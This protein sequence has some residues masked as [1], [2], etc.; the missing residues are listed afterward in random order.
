M[1]GHLRSNLIGYVALFVALGG[2]SYAA[3][4]ITTADLK[5]GVVTKKKL[6]RNAVVPGK[7]RKGAVTGPKVSDGAITGPK[8]SDGAIDGAKLAAGA[9]GTAKLLDGAVTG[10]KVEESTLGTVPDA[11]KLAGKP[12][13]GFESK[14]F[15]GGDSPTVNL[16]SNATTEVKALALPAGTYLILARGGINNNG[17][18]VGAGQSCAVAAGA[19]AQTISFGALGANG[20]AGDRE[21]F[22]AVVV[23]TLDTAANATL[24]CTTNAAWAAGNITDPTLA[25]VSLQP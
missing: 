20:K 5:N 15:G 8:V 25:A 22:D 4:T 18:E 9:V 19:A 24:S 2:V 3:G 12:P 16:P 11:A 23:A 14:G 17:P 6:H 13:A 10:A 7:I 21:E 1:L